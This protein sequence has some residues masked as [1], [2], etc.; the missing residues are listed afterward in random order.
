MFPNIAAFNE[1]ELWFTQIYRSGAARNYM[2]FSDSR[3]DS[4]IDKQRVTFD[5]KERKAVIREIITYM[6]D[7]YPGTNGANT[8]ILNA[9]NPKVRDYSPESYMSG[10]Q[11]EWVWLDT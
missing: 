1:P 9:V 8:L 2:N 7:H 4:L 10:S 6:L 11:Y 5:V 3:V